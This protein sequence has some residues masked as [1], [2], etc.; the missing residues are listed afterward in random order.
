MG[1]SWMTRIQFPAGA[2]DF[3][4]FHKNHTGSDITQS[5]LQWLSEAPFPGRDMKLTSYS[6]EVTN[7]GDI[8]PLP[9][10][11]QWFRTGYFPYFYLLLYSK[12]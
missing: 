12:Y 6:A 1:Y 3:S 4:L 2:R 7:G 5:P 10:T 8:P 9:H 11:Y